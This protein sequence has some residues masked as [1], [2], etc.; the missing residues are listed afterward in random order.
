[1]AVGD[2]VTVSVNPDGT[3]M[4]EEIG[5]RRSMFFRPSK[6]S[7]SKKQ[8][9]A[10]NIS[11]LAAVA[12]VKSPDLK[13]GLIDRFL[14]AAEIGGLKPLVIVNKIDLG[15]IPLLDEIKNGYKELGIDF[16]ITSAIT[17]DGIDQLND[18]LKDHKTI[19]AGHSGVGKTTILNNLIPGLNLKVGEVSEATDRGIHTTT[20]VELF[21]LP[22]GGFVIDSPGLKVLGLWDMEKEDLAWHF[23]EMQNYLEDCRFTGCTHTH[24]P[25]CAVKEAVDSGKIFQFRYKSYVTIYN[26]L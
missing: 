20:S 7:E 2:D 3:G 4:I 18:T 12:S 24:E 19:F 8:I 11:Q 9:I 23:P 13:P 14:I 26:S 25:D 15:S 5:E 21:E 16:C 1:V 10:S 6:K 17:G 22:E